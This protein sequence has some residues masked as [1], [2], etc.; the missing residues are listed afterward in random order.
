MENIPTTAI[1]LIAAVIL[2]AL[3]AAFGFRTWTQQQESGNEALAQNEAQNTQM[4]EAQYTQYDGEKVAGSR[5]LSAI[6]LAKDGNVAICVNN[7]I[8]EYSYIYDGLSSSATS[9]SV[10][11]L[12]KKTTFS[13]DLANAKNPTSNYYISNSATYI[14]SIVRD[15]NTTQITGL[16][17]ATAP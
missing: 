1:I 13:T 9:F 10:T 7:G 11:G 5:V 12:T 8:A 2:A 15:P 14:G 16:I 17:F 3:L 4:L 6:K